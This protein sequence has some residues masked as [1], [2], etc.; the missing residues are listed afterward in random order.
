MKL[1]NIKGSEVLPKRRYPHDPR[2]AMPKSDRE[3]NRCVQSLDKIGVVGSLDREGL[4]EA[5]RNHFG[6]IEL[7]SDKFKDEYAKIASE[8]VNYSMTYGLA[9]AII[10]HQSSLIELELVVEKEKSK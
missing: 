2:L 4:A 10:A 9:D 3:W 5:I 1:T 8:V 6:I 7:T